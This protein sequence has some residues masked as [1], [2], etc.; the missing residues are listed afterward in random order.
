MKMYRTNNYDLEIQEREITKETGH[1]LFWLLTDGRRER[2]EMR[3]GPYHK[4]HESRRDALDY[5]HQQAIKKATNA[6]RMLD[7]ATEEFRLIQIEFK[8]LKEEQ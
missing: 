6:Q 2:R 5:L 8:H 1:Y 3:V 4:W 7:K